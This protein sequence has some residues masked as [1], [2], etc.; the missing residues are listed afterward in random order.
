MTRL[1]FGTGDSYLGT[2]D[3]FIFRDRGYTYT[4]EGVVILRIH[5]HKRGVVIYTQEGVSAHTYTLERHGHPTIY[6]QGVWSCLIC[7]QKG[8][9]HTYTHDIHTRGV[10]IPRIHIHMNI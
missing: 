2:S 7:T 4:Q 5:T 6:T 1:Y 8:C 10:V 3:L 9:V